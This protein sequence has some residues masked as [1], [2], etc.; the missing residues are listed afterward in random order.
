MCRPD[1][2]ILLC[3]RILV[4][5]LR[6]ANDARIFESGGQPS[7]LSDGRAGQTDKWF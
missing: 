7:Q 2:L 4:T 5:A 3:V 6:S 1:T